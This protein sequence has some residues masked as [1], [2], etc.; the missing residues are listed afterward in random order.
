MFRLRVERCGGF[1]EDEQQRPLA[2]E[3]AGEGDALPLAVGE[4]DPAEGPSEVA[5]VLP[6]V[7]R[8][9]LAAEQDGMYVS[10]FTYVLEVVA[11]V[12]MPAVEEGDENVITSFFGVC[13]ELLGLNS[14]LLTE[15]VDDL[16]AKLLIRYYPHLISQ[17]G[18]QLQ[19]LIATH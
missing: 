6:E 1:V 11:E 18:P 14:G 2:H 5:D 12:F 3:A 10:M 8:R 16:V 4:L 9:R 15:S 17:S 19:K 7:R 13:E